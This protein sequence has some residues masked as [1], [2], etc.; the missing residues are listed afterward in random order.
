MS[1]ENKAF[2]EELSL[3]RKY[4]YEF[5]QN[6]NIET[7]ELMMKCQQNLHTLYEAQDQSSEIER[8]KA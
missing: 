3:F 7:Y 5:G 1:K 6:N 4:A 2:T 8:L